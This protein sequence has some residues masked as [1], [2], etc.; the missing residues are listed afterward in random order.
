MRSSKTSGFCETTCSCAKKS[1]KINKKDEEEIKKKKLEV[2]H[3]LPLKHKMEET[4][5]KN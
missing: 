5:K 4:K 2:S 3:E 1:K